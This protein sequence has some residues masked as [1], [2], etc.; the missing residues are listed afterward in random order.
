MQMY[1][2]LIAVLNRNQQHICPKSPFDVYCRKLKQLSALKE[3]VS[4]NNE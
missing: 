1:I 4:I 3:L 2:R